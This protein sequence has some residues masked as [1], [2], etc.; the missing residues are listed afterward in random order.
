MYPQEET[1]GFFVAE[2]LG[3]DDIALVAEQPAGNGMDDAGLVRAGEG[4]YVFL[5]GFNLGSTR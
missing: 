4:E 2:L 1:P 3:V 5:H